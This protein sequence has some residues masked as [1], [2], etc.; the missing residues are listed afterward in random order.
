MNPEPKKSMVMVEL[1]DYGYGSGTDTDWCSPGSP[2]SSSGDD[3]RGHSIYPDPSVPLGLPP[4]PRKKPGKYRLRIEP[5]AS[6]KEKREIRRAKNREAAQDLRNRKLAYESDLRAR[7]AAID[8]E[9]AALERTVATL[10][11]R[12]QEMKAKIN[13]RR[14]ELHLTTETAEGLL[15]SLPSLGDRVWF[16][17]I[18]GGTDMWRHLTAQPAAVLELD[19]TMAGADGEDY[20]VDI[21]GVFVEQ[22]LELLPVAAPPEL[23]TFSNAWDEEQEIN[24]EVDNSNG[25]HME[26]LDIDVGES[27]LALETESAELTPQQSGLQSIMM[28]L[29]LAA[30]SWLQTRVTAVHFSETTSTEVS[31]GISPCRRLRLSRKLISR[32]ISILPI[33]TQ[34]HHSTGSIQPCCPPFLQKLRPPWAVTSHVLLIT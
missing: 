32:S 10:R 8:S 20:L 15:L 28:L 2:A 17:D 31:S 12:Q 19:M 24:K 23:A 27:I 26:L 11:F 33:S 3:M 14:L 7:G 16:T 4:N 1:S 29:L 30:M 13:A 9:N 34:N 22:E 21:D 5:A 18:A 6:E 25:F